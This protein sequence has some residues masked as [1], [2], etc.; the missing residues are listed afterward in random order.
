MDYFLLN[1]GKPLGSLSPNLELLGGDSNSQLEDD[2]HL[3]EL[4]VL[5]ISRGKAHFYEKVPVTLSGYR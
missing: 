5:L 1:L 4:K 2:R 3:I